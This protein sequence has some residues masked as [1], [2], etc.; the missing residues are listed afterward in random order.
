M[1]QIIRTA[2]CRH[3]EQCETA[4]PPLAEMLLR[5][6]RNWRSRDGLDDQRRIR[7]E[8]GEERLEPESDR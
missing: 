3:R 5:T 6:S 7:S 2:V 8:W 1:A 4:E